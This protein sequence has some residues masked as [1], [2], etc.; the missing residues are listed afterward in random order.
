MSSAGTK[1]DGGSDV[2]TDPPLAAACPSG[3]YLTVTL[4]VEVY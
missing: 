2:A 3:T 4:G 1:G